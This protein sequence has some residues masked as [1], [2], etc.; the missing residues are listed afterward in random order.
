[1]PM[2][3]SLDNLTSVVPSQKKKE[4]WVTQSI[5]ISI[6]LFTKVSVCRCR[7]RFLG[8]K[9]VFSPRMLW[10]KYFFIEAR[11]FPCVLSDDMTNDH[12]NVQRRLHFL[13][14]RL[15]VTDIDIRMC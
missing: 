13:R 1:M 5:S 12:M 11:D 6:S 8:V 9:A 2:Y 3:D 7:L 10:M 15:V 4:N 14:T